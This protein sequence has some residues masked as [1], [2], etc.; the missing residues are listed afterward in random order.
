MTTSRESRA[1]EYHLS[2]AAMPLLSV[3]PTDGSLIREHAGR[4]LAS[5]P[6]CF[7][8]RPS[9]SASDGRASPA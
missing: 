9:S 3:N 2:Q 4:P 1:D 6:A 5:G 7:G 8:A